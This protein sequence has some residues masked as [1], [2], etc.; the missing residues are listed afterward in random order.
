MLILKNCVNIISN[1]I[2]HGNKH[3]HSA[4]TFNFKS[5]TLQLVTHGFP[6]RPVK[7]SELLSISIRPVDL[8]GLSTPVWMA[9]SRVYPDGV[10]LS[11]S[12][13]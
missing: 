4:S 12:C 7:H 11:R 2:N 3:A 13:M 9:M 8:P 6:G 10:H 5:H 1:K